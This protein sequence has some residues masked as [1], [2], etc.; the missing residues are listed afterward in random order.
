MKKTFIP[1]IMSIAMFGCASVAVTS[2]S[3]EDRTSTALHLSKS[4]FSIIQREDKGLE[5]DYI[6]KTK[7]GT[8]YNC[9]VTGGMSITGSLVSDAVCSKA[10]TSKTNS[11]TTGKTS[12]A[13]A[14]N[15]TNNTQCNAL[16]K[17]ANKC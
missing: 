17:A 7:S 4:D 3:L 11:K 10:I 14:A 15:D 9:Y 8:Q 16:L 12:K 13:P 1:V 6:V 2:D 5:T